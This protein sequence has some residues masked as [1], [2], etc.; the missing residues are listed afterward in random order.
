MRVQIALGFLASGSPLLR[1]PSVFAQYLEVVRFLGLIDVKDPL[2]EG[3]V[4]HS[5][6]LAWRIPGAG[7]PGGL[8]SMGR[9]GSDTTEAT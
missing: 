2:E 8:P 4:T 3:M 6:V 7:E 1:P 9:S 5:S